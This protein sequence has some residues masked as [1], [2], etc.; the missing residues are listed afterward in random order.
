MALRASLEG[1]KAALLGP[2]CPPLLGGSLLL[3]TWSGSAWILQRAGVLGVTVSSD[4][5]EHFSQ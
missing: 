5:Q 4:G 3:L 1:V 2:Q